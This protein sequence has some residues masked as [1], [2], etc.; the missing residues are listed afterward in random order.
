MLDELQD[1]CVA[2]L[3]W[4]PFFT[5]VGRVVNVVKENSLDLENE[6]RAA[7]DRLGACVTVN[8]PGILPG[9]T[10]DLVKVPLVFGISEMVSLNRSRTGARKTAMEIGLRIMAIVRR[11][12]PGEIWAP[13]ELDEGGLARVGE[14]E[15]GCDHWALSVYTQTQLDVQVPA[16]GTHDGFLIGDGKGAILLAAN[17]RN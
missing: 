4:D 11:W 17:A 1:L 6:W 12:S 10:N 15:G 13:F 8:T 14:D 3:N 2:R 9:N 5:E 7:M 16:L